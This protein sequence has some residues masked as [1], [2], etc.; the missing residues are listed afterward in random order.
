MSLAQAHRSW[1]MSINTSGP[2]AIPQSTQF[3]P[4]NLSEPE[5]AREFLINLSKDLAEAVSTRNSADSKVFLVEHCA[6]I[7]LRAMARRDEGKANA[8]FESR[9]ETFNKAEEVLSYCPLRKIRYTTAAVSGKTATVWL[10]HN[11]EDR[12]GLTRE[13]VVVVYWKWLTDERRW[14]WTG[15]EQSFG[16][17]S[18]FPDAS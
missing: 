11:L 5:A 18:L 16:A 4:S 9:T 10:M 17:G 14:A 13:A 8:V 12:D 1:R 6:C 7:D 15:V 2:K 3:I